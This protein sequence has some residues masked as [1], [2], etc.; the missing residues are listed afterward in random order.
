MISLIRHDYKMRFTSKRINE[1]ERLDGVEDPVGL[2]NGFGADG[3]IGCGLSG[4][5][6]LNGV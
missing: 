3:G 5:P 1:V 6:L 2:P 4:L